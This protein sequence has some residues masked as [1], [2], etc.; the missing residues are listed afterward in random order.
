[1]NQVM[2]LPALTSLCV[3]ALVHGG[4]PRPVAEA[5]AE[6]IVDAEVL[7]HSSH[8][9]M[10][11]PSLVKL[12]RTGTIDPSATPRMSEEGTSLTA[13]LR[14]GFAQYALPTVIDRAVGIARRHGMCLVLLND[15][16]NSGRLGAYVEQ[17]AAAGAVALMVTGSAWVPGEATVAPAGSAQRVFG[18]NPIA[19][20]APAQD[21]VLVVDLATSTTT[22]GHLRLGRTL[23]HP[24]AANG[25]VDREG[26]LSSS[27][28]DFYDN[29][30]LSPLG[31][32]K[33]TSLALLV[34]ALSALSGHTTSDGQ[35]AGGLMLICSPR[36]AMGTGHNA[37][38]TALSAAMNR[39]RELE[40]T[41]ARHPLR[42]PGQS[43][44]AARRH[45]AQY[46]VPVP[47]SLIDALR[48][49]QGA[50]R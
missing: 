12:V 48:S 35:L 25:V 31:G 2:S 7:R 29:G 27:A 45:A 21:E 39:L 6:Q 33:G 14:G 34:A 17:A 36:A 44:P 5:V 41:D 9:L 28:Q 15:L 20:A 49:L 3:G 1:M 16:R 8:G 38:E 30:A 19:F 11:V 26:R 18:T 46:G 43:Y 13:D 24:I 50:E 40:P 42:T 47:T 4:V 23:Q 10:L 22:M 32:H 37:Y